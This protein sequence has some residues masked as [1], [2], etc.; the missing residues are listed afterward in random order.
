MEISEL[1]PQESKPKTSDSL[2]GALGSP[3]KEEN[4]LHKPIQE[5]MLQ[6]FR[7]FES[8]KSEFHRDRIKKWMQCDLNLRKTETMIEKQYQLSLSGDRNASENVKEG[9]RYWLELVLLQI[10]RIVEASG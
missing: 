10:K 6:A 3:E 9:M 1:I 2:Q 8:I 5:A 7:E 4:I